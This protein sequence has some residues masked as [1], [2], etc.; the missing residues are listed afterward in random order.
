VGEDV[1][2]K[3]LQVLLK[4]LGATIA[5]EHGEEAVV[6]LFA[7][8]ASAFA[9]SGDLP[10]EVIREM[11]Q[12]QVDLYEESVLSSSSNFPDHALITSRRAI[13]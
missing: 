3:G 9:R 6:S 2:L 4:T 13:N 5:E 11:Y 8:T 10:V 12:Q 1:S 7:A